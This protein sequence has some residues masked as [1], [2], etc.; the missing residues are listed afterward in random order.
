[1]FDIRAIYFPD[2]VSSTQCIKLL[3]QLANEGTTLVLTVHQP[4]GLL[5]QMFDHIY[6]VADG[7]CIYQGAGVNLIKFFKDLDHP[8]PCFYNPADFLLEIATGTYGEKNRY[9][10]EKIGNG[11]SEEYRGGMRSFTTGEEIKNQRRSDNRKKFY[12]LL[13]KNFLVSYRDKSFTFL[14]LFIHVAVGVLLGMIYYD[15][16]NNAAQIL[17]NFR[18]IFVALSFLVYTSYYSTMMIFPLNFPCIRREIFNRWYSEIH[19]FMALFFS[20]LPILTLTNI[21]FIIPVYFLTSQP[22]EVLRIA[23]FGLIM[24]LTSLVSQSFGLVCGSFVGVKV[25]K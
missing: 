21:I 10:I 23:A 17:N 2:S 11:K 5:I 4:S 20:D 22:F 25:R 13:R 16:G 15:I 6:A 12:T 14:R 7:S 9:L 19:W 18:L 3:R 1:M 24:I 8:C